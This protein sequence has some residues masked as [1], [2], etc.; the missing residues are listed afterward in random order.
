MQDLGRAYKNTATVQDT[1]PTQYSLPQMTTMSHPGQVLPSD[2]N[3]LPDWFF[4]GPAAQYRNLLGFGVDDMAWDWT[5]PM[6]IVQN[7]SGG[8]NGKQIPDIAVC[9]VVIMHP[10]TFSQSVWYKVL[11]TRNCGTRSG[12]HHRDTATVSFPEASG[13][14]VVSVAHDELL[15]VEMSSETCICTSI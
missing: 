12:K 10:L 6:L 4:V 1:T 7:F 9:Q 2:S 14:K 15:V 3:N 5:D 13:N 8:T 11:V